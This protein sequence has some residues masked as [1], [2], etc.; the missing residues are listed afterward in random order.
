MRNTTM[1]VWLLLSSFSMAQDKQTEELREYFKNGMEEMEKKNYAEAANSFEK[2]SAILPSQPYLIYLSAQANTRA[3]NIKDGALWLDKLVELGFTGSARSGDVFKPILTSPEYKSLA[4]KFT[5]LGK[6]VGK[7]EIAFTVPQRNLIAEGI[8]YDSI[9]DRFLVGSTYLRKIISISKDGKVADFATSKND[10]W[11]VL[12]M[13]VDPVRGVLWAVT[14]AFGPE[15]T[16]YQPE[17]QGKSAVMKFDLKSRKI[18]KQYLLENKPDT[19]GLNDLDVNSKGDVFITDTEKG[20]VY[21]I[22]QDQDKLSVFL[23]PGTFRYPNGIAISSDEKHL[24]V[25]HWQ[26]ISIVEIAGK[27]VSLLS[28]SKNVAAAGIDG[29]YFYKNT[30]IGVQNSYTPERIIQ[31]GLDKS[32]SAINMAEVLAANHPSY[33]I[34][35]TGT[36]ADGYFFYIA[37]SQLDSFDEKR[38]ILPPDKLQDLVILKVQLP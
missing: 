35:T 32:F 33:N 30:L 6:P 11:Q 23:E 27:K 16:D 10:L 31:L 4:A 22:R 5:A 24:F 25:A 37:N 13:K 29:L 12:G 14:T 7:S 36:I 15:M 28:T 8:A 34:P 19:H 17:D 2:A 38:Q 1:T 18:I 9:E 21:V 26:G 20:S 3:G